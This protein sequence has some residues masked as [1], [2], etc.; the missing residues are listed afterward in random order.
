MDD[1][2]SLKEVVAAFLRNNPQFLEEFPDVLE[3]L[4]LNHSSGVAVSLIE[5]QVEH[6]RQKNQ[7]IDRQLKRLAHVA[8]ENEQ[9]MTRLHQLTLELMLISSRKEFFTHLGNSLL[10]DFNA[11]I[12]QICLFDQ[13]VAGQALLR[14]SQKLLKEGH[15]FQSLWFAEQ[16]NRQFAGQEIGRRGQMALTR[17][18]VDYLSSEHSQEEWEHVYQR[19]N[20]LD[21]YLSVSWDN[22]VERA[23]I[24][25]HAP[26]PDIA[27]E[28]LLWMGRGYHVLDDIP[29]AIQSYR[30]LAKI[31]TSEAWRRDAQHRLGGILN[32]QIQSL[33]E[34]KA[35]VRLLK[36]HEEQREVF[37]EL[38][39]ERDRVRNVAQAYQHINLPAKAMQ[40]Y[41]QLLETYPE[42]PL[43]EEILAQKVFLADGHSQADEL[44]TAGEVYLHEYPEGHW[45]ADVSLLLGME[46]VGREDYQEA[47]E[48]EP[49]TKEE[50]KQKKAKI[51]KMTIQVS[52]LLVGKHY[53][54]AGMYREHK[55]GFNKAVDYMVAASVGTGV[56]KS[57]LKMSLEVSYDREMPIGDLAEKIIKTEIRYAMSR[58]AV[59]AKYKEQHMANIMRYSM[60]LT[61]KMYIEIN[62]KRVFQSINEKHRVMIK[63]YV[64]MIRALQ[65]IDRPLCEL[66]LKHRSENTEITFKG[67]FN[68][69]P[70]STREKMNKEI[71]TLALARDSFRD[72]IVENAAFKKALAE[73]AT[74]DHE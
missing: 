32:Q 65:S 22:V 34:Q 74:V 44:R 9:L 19:L 17:W 28:S 15:E 24:L 29:S 68:V 14:I 10:H 47:I 31:S 16:A 39:L 5:R 1:E 72:I 56:T 11:D 35:W 52:R 73:L 8:T 61:R 25:S 33:Y 55:R 54:V 12:L 30:H 51:K 20:D 70:W 66:I 59:F 13:E 23:R 60:E 58:R 21:I 71:V 27:E 4:H 2:T 46:S 7:D 57:A 3:I 41:D 42:S 69:I 38:P 43:R 26:E 50:K 63:A 49:E 37:H 67:V 45:R 48:M 6:L 18:V 36:F 62:S 53:T 40:W 64:E